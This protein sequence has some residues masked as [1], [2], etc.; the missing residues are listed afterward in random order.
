M[1]PAA[2]GIIVALTVYAL[3]KDWKVALIVAAVHLLA[4]KIEIGSL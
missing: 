4:H 2:V 3:T 1:K